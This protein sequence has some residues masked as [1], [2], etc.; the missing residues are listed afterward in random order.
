MSH[1]GTFDLY[2]LF[3]IPIPDLLSCNV[4]SGEKRGVVAV[5]ITNRAKIRKVVVEKLFPAWGL[6]LV[7]QWYWLKE[8]CTIKPIGFRSSGLRGSV[9]RDRTK[10][11]VDCECAKPAFSQTIYNGPIVRG[12]SSHFS[13]YKLYTGEVTTQSY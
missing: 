4:D 6:E 2:E 9:G 11:Q 10:A 12:V 5:W 8:E 1:Y 7:A 13:T 3:K